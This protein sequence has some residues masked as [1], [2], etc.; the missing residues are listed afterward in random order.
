MVT[1]RRY[2]PSDLAALH[3]INQASTPGVSSETQADLGKWIGLSTCLVAEDADGTP[4]GSLTL[5]EAGT[6][7]YPSANL[8]WCEAN[9]EDFIYVDRIAV[10]ET[11]RGQ[12]VGEALY[13]AAFEAYASKA[14]QIT[15]EVNR[16]PPNPGSQ[17]FHERL[18]FVQ[19]GSNIF[20]PGE[21]EVIYYARPLAH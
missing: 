15:C 1:I 11:A 19:I 16:Q 10:A 20:V 13:A 14:G 21:K 9:C 2:T 17:R 7:D 3:A 4:L 8:R 18:G 6:L 12:K 5:I